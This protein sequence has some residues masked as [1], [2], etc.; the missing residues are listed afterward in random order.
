MALTEWEGAKVIAPYVSLPRRACEGRRDVVP[1]KDKAA[2][3][4]PPALTSRTDMERNRTESARR[5]ESE[6]VPYEIW[7]VASVRGTS[8]RARRANGAKIRS[9]WL[10]SGKQGSESGECEHS[11]NAFTL[12]FFCPFITPGPYDRPRY[13]AL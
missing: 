13:R 11:V 12:A 2:T 9:A 3:F 7:W 10:G 1:S 6:F 4:L 8:R 5:H